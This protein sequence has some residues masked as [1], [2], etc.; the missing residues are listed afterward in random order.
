M[1]EKICNIKIPKVW[2]EQNRELSDLPFQS[3]GYSFVCWRGLCYEL[4]TQ[5]LTNDTFGWG[6]ELSWDLRKHRLIHSTNIHRIATTYN[7]LAMQSF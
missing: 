2:I 7:Y 4:Q 5:F 1:G 3:L 6:V